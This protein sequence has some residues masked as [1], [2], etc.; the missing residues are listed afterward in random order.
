MPLPTK[1]IKT[2]RCLRDTVPD[3]GT[4]R[5]EQDITSEVK[6]ISLSKTHEFKK[7]AGKVQNPCS[8]HKYEQGYSVKLYAGKDKFS[9]GIMC[10]T[11][12]SDLI[13]RKANEIDP[14]ARPNEY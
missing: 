6:E 5:Y 2:P 13:L 8:T 11:C 1:P 12:A 14:P 3:I 9:E 7:L 4:T 10:L